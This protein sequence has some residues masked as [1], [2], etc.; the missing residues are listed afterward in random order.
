[1]HTCTRTLKSILTFHLGHTCTSIC[2]PRLV[3]TYERECVVVCCSVLHCVAVCTHFHLGRTCTSTCTPRLVRTYERECVA[4]CCSVLQC[5]AAC[6]PIA[7]LGVHAHPH[8]CLDFYARHVWERMCCSVL[9]CVAVCCSVLQ[10]VAVC[11]SV[12]QCVAVC[13]SVLQ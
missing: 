10:C 6:T 4:V 7:S 8:V 2:A 1:M 9:K 13:C 12:L 5:A 11:C 3:R